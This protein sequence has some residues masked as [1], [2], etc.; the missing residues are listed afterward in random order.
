LRV[1]HWP[2]ASSEDEYE[3]RWFNLQGKTRTLTAWAG[4]RPFAWV[5]DEI[6]DADIE[7]VSAHHHGRVL[8][9]PVNAAQ[10]HPPRPRSPSGLVSGSLKLAASSVLTDARTLQPVAVWQHTCSNR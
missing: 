7:W 9:H 6:S 1:V 5:D 2:E 4:G 10:G 8:L 3:V